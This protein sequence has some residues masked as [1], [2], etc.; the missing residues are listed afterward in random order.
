VAN[1]ALTGRAMNRSQGDNN[2]A[3]TMLAGGAAIA[4]IGI[5]GA[6]VGGAVCPVCIVAAPALLGIGAARKIRAARART[7]AAEEEGSR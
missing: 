6:I 4:A 7:R 5:A 1:V 2:E 3:N